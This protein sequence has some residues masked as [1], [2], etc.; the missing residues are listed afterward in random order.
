LKAL[1]LAAGKG[2]RMRPLTERT[3]KPLLKVG[4]K[5]LI[6]H[7][8]ERLRASGITDFLVNLAYLGEQISDYLGDGA[9]LGVSIEYSYEPYPLEVGGAI[10]RALGYLGDEPFIMANADVWSDYNF[11]TLIEKPLRPQE[12]ARLLMVQNP[13][14][15]QKGDFVLTESGRL[16]R[17]GEGSP[18]TCTYSGMA[19]MN[20]ALIA[21]YPL[22]REKFALLEVLHHAIDRGALGGEFYSGEW[23]DIGTPERLSRL[24]EQ[25][26]D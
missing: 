7:T 14:F 1:I 5:P 16:N 23:Q 3:P 11:Q 15:H 17:A 21:E 13:D 19:L 4:G 26:S 25:L 12:L 24:N 10:A 22:Q 20:P 2:E 8:I 18:D 6:V 9:G